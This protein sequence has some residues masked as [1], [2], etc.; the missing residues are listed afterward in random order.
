M[1]D[2]ATETRLRELELTAA[3][4]E[5]ALALSKWLIGGLCG[6]FAVIIVS[7]GYIFSTRE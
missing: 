3:K 1:S 5:T 4:A 6:A 7:M 2:E